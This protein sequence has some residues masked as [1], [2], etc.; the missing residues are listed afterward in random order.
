MNSRLVPKNVN[1]IATAPFVFTMVTAL[2]LTTSDS[3]TAITQKSSGVTKIGRDYFG[4]TNPV[5]HYM[6]T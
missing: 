2:V 4:S 5:Y 1:E 6:Y 3:G